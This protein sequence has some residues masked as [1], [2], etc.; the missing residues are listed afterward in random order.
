MNH[1]YPV[2]LK[3]GHYEEW[4]ILVGICRLMH[5]FWWHLGSFTR[6]QACVAL[7]I[8][9]LMENLFTPRQKVVWEVCQ[10]S[11]CHYIW[12]WKIQLKA[13]EN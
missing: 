3:E 13:I 10:R 4:W 5:S 2:R 1:E 11:Q 9:V 12:L 7:F 8:T 6:W